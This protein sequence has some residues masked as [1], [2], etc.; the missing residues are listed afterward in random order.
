MTENFYWGSGSSA[1]QVEGSNKNDF[2]EGGLDARKATDHYNLFEKDFDIAKSLNQNAHRFS[3][4]WSRIEPEQGRYDQEAIE[5]YRKV[6]MALRDRG[7]EPFVTL[8]HF[9][10]PT[11]IDWRDKKSANYFAR[12]AQT[13]VNHFKDKVKY[14]V[15]LNE[16]EI[17]SDIA[18]ARGKWPTPL[19]KGDTPFGF[20]V[21]GI[22]TAAQVL[23]NL[24]TAHIMAYDHCKT[25]HPTGQ[26]GIATNLVGSGPIG[27]RIINY[28]NR[29]TLRKIKN[30]LDFIGLN[31]YLWVDLLMNKKLPISDIGW[32][33]YPKGIYK[34]ILSLRKYKKPIFITENGV[35]DAE[36]KL[37][38][39][40]IKDHIGWM[41]K[42]MEKGADVKG[43]FHWSLTDNYEW[44]KG[45][46]ARFGLVEINYKTM[47]RKIR[48][49]AYEYAKII[50]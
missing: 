50:Q 23:K 2:S 27:R 38:T 5:H 35:A 25:I 37:R 36:D 31:Y 6:I 4:E 32:E 29:A 30:K 49:S 8:W 39:N 14:W 21:H 48:P 13:I 16:P 7:L 34:N 43:Y 10:N 40:F 45:F 12:F 42:A 26:F 1:H 18:Y 28:L 46:D 33:I 20:H 41:K 11:W 44:H 47:E 15:I 9:T 22:F 3:I 19:P 17:Y 24:R